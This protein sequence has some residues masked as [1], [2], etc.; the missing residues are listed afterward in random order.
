M[1]ESAS[2]AG[3]PEVEI[4]RL[5]GA[6]FIGALLVKLLDIAYQELRRRSERRTTARRFV[7]ENLDPVLRAADEVVGKLRSLATEDFQT[8]RGARSSQ[9]RHH[10]LVDILYLLARLWAS[11][12]V[13]R[14]GAQTVSVVRDRR[15][16]RLTSFMDCM[17]SRGVRILRRSSQRA[18]AEL[19]LV[20]RD[21][22]QDTIRFVDFVRMFEEDEEARRWLSPLTRAF[23]RMEHTADRQRLLRYGIVI[24]AMIDDLDPRHEVSRDRPSYPDKLSRRSWRDLKYR[25]FRVYLTDVRE[26][27]KYLGPPTRRP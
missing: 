7:D 2:P 23:D 17:E 22:G 11:L 8:L 10:D 18:V 1:E 19:L 27:E 15:G 13:F 20:P 4:L 14:N 25:V 16:K 12:E 6:G 26:T 5:I 3:Q 21:G 9:A 24:H